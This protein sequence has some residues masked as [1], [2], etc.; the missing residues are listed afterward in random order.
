L[1]YAPT[2]LSVSAA[3]GLAFL[4]GWML[5]D[6]FRACALTLGLLIGYVGYSITHHAV[7]YWRSD[8]ATTPILTASAALRCQPCS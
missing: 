8:N 7:H 5:G 6:R 1:I 2:I 4:S 3:T